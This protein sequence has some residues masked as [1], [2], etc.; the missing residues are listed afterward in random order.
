MKTYAR[1][2]AKALVVACVII[3]CVSES[4]AQDRRS[5]AAALH[6]QVFV[7][8]TV[9]AAANSQPA[10]NNPQRAVVTFDI[11]SKNQTQTIQT[12]RP[13]VPNGQQTATS[14]EKAVLETSTFVAE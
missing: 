10:A 6:I 8:P 9:I 12:L 13:L 7:M 1:R 14:A 5:A 4:Q 2:L 11:P 3:S